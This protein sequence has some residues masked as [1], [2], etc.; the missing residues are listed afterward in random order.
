MP[1]Q[2][3]LKAIRISSLQKLLQQDPEKPSGGPR[4]GEFWRH[5]W[6][7]MCC[8]FPLLK[9]IPEIIISQKLKFYLDSCLLSFWSTVVWLCLL[10]DLVA[11]FYIMWDGVIYP[12][13][14]GRQEAEERNCGLEDSFS[15]HPNSQ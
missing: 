15:V 6:W 5:W 11:R 12:H 7:A 8:S 9:E 14:C 1:Q 13:R 3:V 10:F 2:S 4:K